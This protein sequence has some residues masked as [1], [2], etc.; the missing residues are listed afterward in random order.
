MSVSVVL[1]AC[2]RQ[3]RTNQGELW[4]LSKVEFL[5]SSSGFHRIWCLTKVGLSMFPVYVSFFCSNI[6]HFNTK[7]YM[8]SSQFRSKRV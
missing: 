5:W 8:M 3:G 1:W 6:T 4:V 2:F 7:L